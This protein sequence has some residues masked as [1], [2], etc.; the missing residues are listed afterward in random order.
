MFLYFPGALKSL[1]VEV[2]KFQCLDNK[3]S[4]SWKNELF[5]R[6]WNL[7]GICLSWLVVGGGGCRGLFRCIK[8][9]LLVHIV[10][11]KSQK[12]KNDEKFR[13]LGISIFSSFSF[14]CDEMKTIV[15]LST[16]LETFAPT[17]LFY[18]YTLRFKASKTID[19]CWGVHLIKITTVH[20]T[21]YVLAF[22]C[23]IQK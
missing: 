2:L 3:T 8:L 7:G 4:K 20:I 18:T 17:T 6:E 13:I 15:M 21:E 11:E 14:D 5:Q 22:V 19:L 9:K 23:E 16:I 12:Y 10:P 1:K